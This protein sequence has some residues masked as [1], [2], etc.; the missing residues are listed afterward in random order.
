MAQLAGG[1]NI[2][3]NGGC[4]RSGLTITFRPAPNTAFELH[5]TVLAISPRDFLLDQNVPKQE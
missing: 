4:Q 1:L 5:D 3:A 2:Q